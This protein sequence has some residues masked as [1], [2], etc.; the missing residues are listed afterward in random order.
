MPSFLNFF[1]PFY[2][3]FYFL[4]SSFLYFFFF[5]CGIVKFGLFNLNRNP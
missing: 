3:Y 1:F 4:F 5:V 2:F